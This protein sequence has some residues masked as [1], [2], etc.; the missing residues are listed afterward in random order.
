MAFYLAYVLKG[1][2]VNP[3]ADLVYRNMAIVIEFAD[4]A[5]MFMLDTLTHVTLRG[6]YRELIA[7]AGNVLA[8]GLIGSAICSLCR[9]AA[10]SRLMFGITLVLYFVFAYASRFAW[11]KVLASGKWE[12]NCRSLL[13]VTT[14][15]DAQKVV[16]T[17]QSN[18]YG[19]FLLSGL[20][21]VDADMAGQS[22]ADVKVVANSEDAPMYVCQQWIDEVLVVVPDEAPYPEELIKKME[23]TGVTIHLKMSKIADAED[24]RQFVETVGSYTVL[25]TSLNY[26]SAKQLLFKRVMD[27][28][29]GLVGCPQHVSSLSLSHR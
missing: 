8:V 5:A 27:I 20:V 17:V 11:K 26:A 6:R 1:L 14:K 23:E 12:R 15:A 7:T 18:N 2:G 13:I 24:R 25:T 28:A 4:L 22:I 29:G 9:R 16:E 21:I 3:Y 10:F 19:K